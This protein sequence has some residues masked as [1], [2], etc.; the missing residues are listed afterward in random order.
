MFGQ[1]EQADLYA[2]DFIW[3]TQMMLYIAHGPWQDKGSPP[4]TQRIG[5]EGVREINDKSKIDQI[6]LH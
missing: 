3:A 1:I 6:Q 4:L 5:K 2:D